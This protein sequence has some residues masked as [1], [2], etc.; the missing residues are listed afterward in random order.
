MMARGSEEGTRPGLEWID[1][2]VKKF[3][4]STS[5]T[6]RIP[7]MGWNNVVPIRQHVLMKGLD[8]TSRF[9]FLHSYYFECRA[10]PDVLA[11]TEYDGRFT[12]AIA[13]ENIYG[14]QFHPEKSHRWGNQI[15]E[16]FARL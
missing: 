6:I 14:V 13:H 3:A 9:Y 5:Q 16:N 15:L 7:H 4:G 1:G 12:C 8:D 10:T 2:E 11:V